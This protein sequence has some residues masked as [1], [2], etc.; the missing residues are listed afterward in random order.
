MHNGGVRA[1]SRLVLVWTSISLVAVAV[2]WAA[3]SSAI[4]TSPPEPGEVAALDPS[5]LIPKPSPKPITPATA[6]PRPTASKAAQAVTRAGRGTAQRTTTPS[7]T[8]TPRIL[9]AAPAPSPYPAG[10]TVSLPPEL[11]DRQNSPM[12]IV[13][14]FHS[15]GGDATVRFSDG[16][17]YLVS[18]QPAAGYDTAKQPGTELAIAVSFVSPQHTSTISAYVDAD[19]TYHAKII[20]EDR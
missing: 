4:E 17:V 7:P 3:L 9:R 10:D 13:R 14:D 20:E 15:A 12:D 16:H 19:G 2:A 6:L 11:P 18:Y 5:I 1:S 8:P